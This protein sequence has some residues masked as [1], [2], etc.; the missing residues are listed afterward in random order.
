MK[1]R[2]GMKQ[3]SDARLW[4]K[5]AAL[6]LPLLLLGT[7][8]ALV[9]KK[10]PI[11]LPD[12]TQPVITTTEVPTTQPPAGLNPLTGLPLRDKAAVGKRPLVCM[13]N[14]APPARPQWGL[15]AAD[16]VLEGL[17]EGG[18]TRM[19]WMF[20]DVRDMPKIGPIRSARHDFAELARG[21]DAIYIHWGGSPQA[22]ETISSQKVNNINGMKSEG[23]TFHRDKT[24]KVS[25]EHRGYTTGKDIQKAV[26]TKKFRT[27]LGKKYT[28]PFVFAPADKPRK[29]S[30][31]AAA[32]V[33]F[34]F[35]QSYR[36]SFAYDKKTRLYAQSMNEKPFVQDGGKQRT[37]SNIVLLYIDFRVLD[38]KGRVDMDLSEGKGTYISGGT[39]EEISWK[40]GAPADPLQL[41]T[42]DGEPL[43]LNAGQSYIGLVPKGQQGKTVVK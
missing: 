19:L 33:S 24:R 14:N 8:L 37:V 31:S 35:S 5:L 27:A 17:V 36:Y 29:L 16:I 28:E 7:V 12:L 38:S 39:Q 23:S 34:R 1:E 22:Y 32:T 21:L 42:E 41:L 6:A 18:T 30:G 4:G 40:K 10:D 9:L 11:P 25:L 15:C 2:I 13:V 3:T 43:T 26:E 20:A